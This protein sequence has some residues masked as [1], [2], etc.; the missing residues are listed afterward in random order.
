[1][2]LTY[3]KCIFA[4]RLD[5][6]L[7]KIMEIIW[8]I[9]YSFKTDKKW[10]RC[11]YSKSSRNHLVF[12]STFL[13]G[14]CGS[15]KTINQFQITFQFC[16]GYVRGWRHSRMYAPTPPSIHLFC[17]NFISNFNTW[18]SYIL[19][20]STES[21]NNIFLCCCEQICKLKVMVVHKRKVQV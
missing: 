11:T 18:R 14:G 2:N 4:F 10:D 17:F 21:C 1:M 12:I 7:K 3:K 5:F 19:N 15:N 13:W 9:P 20:E 8:L 6:S 16:C